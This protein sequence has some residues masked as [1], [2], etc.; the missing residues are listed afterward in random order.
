MKAVTEIPRLYMRFIFD[1]IDD[2]L[3]MLAG[4]EDFWR[5][6]SMDR[7]ELVKKDLMRFSAHNQQDAEQ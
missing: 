6:L 5:H 7:L 1:D 3:T 4:Q 2:I